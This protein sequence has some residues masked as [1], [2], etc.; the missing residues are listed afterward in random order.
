M[1]RAIFKSS[2][3]TSVRSPRSRTTTLLIEPRTEKSALAPHRE[4]LISIADRATQFAD[5]VQRSVMTVQH[6]LSI[7]GS[8]N[9]VSFP[10]FMKTDPH[11]RAFT[12]S[13]WTRARDDMNIASHMYWCIHIPMLNVF[14][15]CQ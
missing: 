4:L 1:C 8:E 6:R 12:Y 5:A 9:L 10:Q 2:S 11:P 7:L 13:V 14:L 3:F 15:D